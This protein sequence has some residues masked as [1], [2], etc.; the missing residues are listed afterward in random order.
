MVS[1][2]KR[3]K[4]LPLCLAM[5]LVSAIPARAQGPGTP[6]Y[7]DSFYDDYYKSF[8]AARPAEPAPQAGGPAAIQS[9]YARPAAQQAYDPYYYNKPVAHDTK[10]WEIE[11]KYKM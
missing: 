9:A 5:G 11:A 4:G 10:S 8:P 7:Y 1:L 2:L 6:T 3:M